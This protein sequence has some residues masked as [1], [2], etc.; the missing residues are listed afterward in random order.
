MQW[1]RTPRG[2]VAGVRTSL[3]VLFSVSVRCPASVADISRGGRGD[4]EAWNGFGESTQNAFRGFWIAPRPGKCCPTFDLRPR[5]FPSVGSLG[6]ILP[7][8]G[9]LELLHHALCVVYR[10]WLLAQRRPGHPCREM[11]EGTIDVPSA[12]RPSRDRASILA[13]SSCGARGLLSPSE[14]VALATL[15]Q[16]SR[17][18]RPCFPPALPG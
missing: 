3:H 11:S 5:R 17:R 2:R 10:K 16:S 6:N 4:G 13:R 1:S 8:R 18:S 9:S 7:G 12:T 15:A 14:C